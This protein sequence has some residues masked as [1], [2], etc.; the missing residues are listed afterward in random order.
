MKT[1]IFLPIVLLLITAICPVQA[2]HAAAATFDTFQTTEIEGYVKEFSFRN[3]HI[4]IR[5]AVTDENGAE[6]EWVATAPAVAGFRRWGWTDAMLEEGQYVRLVGRASRLGRPMILI[7]RADIEGG[8]LLELNPTDGSLVRILEGPKP[9]QTPDL[10]IPA[11]TLADG[12][13]NLSGTFLALAPGSGGPRENPQFNA[14]GQALQEAFDP[15]T[16]DIAFTECAVRGYIRGVAANQSVRITQK[17]DYVLIEQEGDSSQKLIYL[18]AR[19]ASSDEHTLRGHSTARYDG[20]TLVVNTTQLLAGLTNG[21]G[22]ALSNQ[23]TIEERYRRADDEEHA[24]LELNVT[25]TDPGHLTA[26]WH[27][28]WRKLMVTDYQFAETECQLPVLANS[29]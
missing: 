1:R 2:H 26:P 17:E 9:D 4:T 27:A 13:P 10:T 29:N 19:A 3:P 21:R 22:N 18:D 6:S 14:D 15:A 11:L 24:A 23:V 28:G 12:L 25:F 7:E 16:D 8:K 5:L 20:D